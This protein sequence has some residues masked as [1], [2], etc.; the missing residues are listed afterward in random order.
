MNETIVAVG[1]RLVDLRR[2]LPLVLADYVE[3]ERRGVALP[4]YRKGLT[5]VQLV[6]MVHFVLEKVAPSV[7]RADVLEL[8]FGGAELR[9]I[10]AAVAG[11]EQPLTV[12]LQEDSRG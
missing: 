6:T 7:T 2:A 10:L 4:D 3:L 1:G 9:K 8:A 12:S 11:S 5:A